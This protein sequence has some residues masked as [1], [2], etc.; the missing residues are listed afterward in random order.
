MS[1][2][3]PH[4]R[5]ANNPRP[6]SSTVCQKCLRTG[7]FTYECKSTRPYVSRPSRT[8][9]LE[10][11]RLLAKLKADGNPSIEVPEEF[12]NKSG[13]ADRILE[14][15]EKQREKEDKGRA[16]K[17]TKRSSNAASSSDSSSESDPSTDSGSE[18]SSSGSVSGSSSYSSRSRDRDDKRRRPRARSLSRSSHG[19]ERERSRSPRR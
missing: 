11:P 3:A 14:A 17:R 2:F 8:A 16:K 9:Q 15:K 10:N 12:K 5:S 4:S 6:N 13:T 1:K 7:H 18:T 19:S